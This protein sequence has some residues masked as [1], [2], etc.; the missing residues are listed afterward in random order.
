MTKEELASRLRKGEKL[1][2]ILPL[3]AGQECEMYKADS[4]S[5]GDEILYIP[6]V[7]LN[8][9]PVDADLSKDPEEIEQVIENCYTGN[10][11]IDLCQGNVMNAKDLFYF[12]DWQH[13]SSA[14]DDGCCEEVDTD[15]IGSDL[16]LVTENETGEVYTIKC[17]YV[18]DLLDDWNGECEY[19]PS[20]DAKVF[21]ACWNGKP[22]N[23][24]DFTDFASFMENV[25]EPKFT[26]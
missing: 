21:F 26:R 5:I 25:I 14:L 2:D 3:V 15:L 7:S 10:D 17:K 12:C 1:A 16:F 24:Y 9:I 4:F 6:D 13:P 11:F 20:N 23:P 8:E 18:Q 19:C 22:F